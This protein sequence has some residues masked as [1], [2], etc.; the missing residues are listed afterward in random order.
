MEKELYTEM[1]ALEGSHWWF[2][3]RRAIILSTLARY[4]QRGAFLLDVGVGTGINAQAFLD[5]GYRVA[6]IEPAGEAIRFAKER[7]ASLAVVQDTFPSAQI[8]LHTYDVVTLLDVL[9]HFDDDHAALQ[10]V[11]DVLVPGGFVLITVPAFPFLWTGHDALAHH[12]R[13]YRR[14]QLRKRLSEAGLVPVFVSYYNFF[15]FPAIAAVRVLQNLFRLQ[16]T[17][18]DFSSTPGFLNGPFALLFGF[19]RFLLRL[20]PLPWGVSLIAVARKPKQ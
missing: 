17:E 9:E 11:R 14:A 5:A 16:K 15:L 8:P 19:E 18:S 10:G 1:A 6:G 20:T 2:V 13:R 3:G 4:I 12:K 7:V